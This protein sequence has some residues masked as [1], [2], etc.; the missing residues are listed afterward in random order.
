MSDIESQP[1]EPIE[2]EKFEAIPEE[3]PMRPKRVMSDKQLANLARAREKAGEDG[4]AG[5]AGALTPAEGRG[6]EGR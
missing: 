6:Q 1:I 2:H 3:K 4:A 5:A